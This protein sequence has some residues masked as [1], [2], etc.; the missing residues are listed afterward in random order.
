MLKSLPLLAEAPEIQKI[1][2]RYIA[3]RLMPKD[4][5]GDALHLAIASYYDCKF[6][7]TWNCIHLSQS[8]ESGA[9]SPHKRPAGFAHPGHDNTHE[10]VGRTL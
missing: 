9:Y 8:A 1:V 5:S 3:H 6:L 4:P 7:V 10:P 2:Q